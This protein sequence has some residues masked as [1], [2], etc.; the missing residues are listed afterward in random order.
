MGAHI[1]PTLG[2]EQA[3]RPVPLSRAVLW[4]LYAAL[5]GL[6]LFLSFPPA[7]LWP[8]SYVAFVPLL[9][10]V[11]GSGSYR[12]AV[13]CSVV[14]AAAAYLPSFAWVASVAVSGWLALAL[15]V[16]LYLIV[17]APVILFFQK[18]FAGVW[19]LLAALLWVGLE[20]CRARLQPGFPWL[21]LGYTQYRFAGLLQLAAVGGVYAVS[22]VVFLANASLA[23]LVGG[24]LRAGSGSRRPL[25]IG[26]AWVAVSALLLGTCTI[27]GRAARE[28]VVLTEGPVVGVAQQNIPRL[29]AAVY[30]G[31]GDFLAERQAEVQLCAQLTAT[32]RRSGVRLVVWPETTVSVPLDRAP[33]Y[34]AEKA[35]Q[36]Q[37]LGYLRGLG[38]NMGCYFLVGAPS[39][40]SET[41]TGS[42]LY[43]LGATSEDLNS[44][45]MLDPEGRVVGRY[46]KMRLV[47]FGEY[48]P[49]RETFPFLQALTPIPREI[50]R[51]KEEV[52]FSL[53]LREGNDVVRFGALV[54]YEDVFP[55]LC[56][57]LRRKGAHFLV[58]IAEE[59]WYYIP[60]ERGQHLAMAVFRAV[61]TRTTV[62]RAANT[63]IS[64]FISPRGEVYAALEPLTEGALSAPL[65]LSGADTLYVRYGDA[66]AII[67]LMLAILL[68]SVLVAL[69]EPA[70]EAPSSRR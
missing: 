38:Q 53:P 4:L 33:R 6:L 42:V 29:V 59:G 70:Q 56:V 27:A 13:C 37:A 36:Q 17:A 40:V 63:G 5:S 68:P 34:P 15:Y 54:C 12:V 8:L 46:D 18:R 10:A 22:F 64:C 44:A 31:G 35:L 21:L 55:E 3:D 1:H 19:P 2:S 11:E 26:L 50:S 23:A 14:A 49:M 57:A 25:L 16:G 20:L 24:V 39:T 51:G 65:Q 66:F 52:V 43:G 58:N 61:E 69:A 62:V 47:P 32:L 60:G 67:C 41:V 48:I 28:R 45:V 30:G 9:A 7:D